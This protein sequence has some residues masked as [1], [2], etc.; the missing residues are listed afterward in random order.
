MANSSLPSQAPA[1]TT[2]GLVWLIS[3]GDLLT[4]LVCFFLV[5]TP[6]SAGRLQLVQRQQ[7][8]ISTQALTETPGTSLASQSGGL[9]VS[10]EKLVIARQYALTSSLF[11]EA[12]KA[13]LQE[14]LKSVQGE[15][16]ARRQERPRV[17][18]TICG[19]VARGQVL[20]RL[21]VELTE[22]P[23]INMRLEVEIERGCRN[24]RARSSEADELV[25]SITIAQG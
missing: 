18:L 2:T 16:T 17:I 23:E 3:F 4:L 15:V 8:L 5:L 12:R 9:S 11:Q 19:E 7:Q 6:W 10:R 1:T 20:Q 22:M 24:Q 21:G 13:R 14:V 25:G